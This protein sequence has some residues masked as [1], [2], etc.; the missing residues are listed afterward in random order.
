MAASIREQILATCADMVAGISTSGGYEITVADVVRWPHVQTARA[1]PFVVVAAGDETQAPER[2]LDQQCRMLNVQFELWTAD[3]GTGADTLV[4]ALL[5][6]IQKCILGD[7]TLGGLC[8][9]TDL[10]DVLP[11][12]S[13]TMTEAGALMTIMVY[14]TTVWDDP[15]VNPG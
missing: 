1:K 13:E 15:Y 10:G 11:L 14:Y 7:P 3:D 8:E 4:N 5:A 2:S 6:S 12:I 9:Y